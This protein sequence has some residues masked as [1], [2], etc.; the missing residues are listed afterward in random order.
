M[1]KL[2]LLFPDHK[3]IIHYFDQEAKQAIDTFDRYFALKTYL[4]PFRN[5]TES[6]A[7]EVY[8]STK[9]QLVNEI[10]KI[11]KENNQVYDDIK[12]KFEATAIAV[13]YKLD[14]VNI[15]CFLIEFRLDD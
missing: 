6:Q 3:Y 7:N 9:Y 14:N 5:I 12:Y 15:N 4:I 13:D 10:S 1:K 11:T 2:E 8:V